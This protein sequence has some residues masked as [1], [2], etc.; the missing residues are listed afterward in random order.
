MPMGTSE[1]SRRVTQVLKML[2]GRGEKVSML[3]V[4]GGEKNR[5]EMTPLVL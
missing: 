3:I 1:G 4:V 2:R 5:G